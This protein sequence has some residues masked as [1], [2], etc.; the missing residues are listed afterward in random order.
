MPFSFFIALR[1]LQPKRT[2][3][4]IMTLLSV[5]GVCLGVTV[6]MVVIAVMAGFEKRI[7]DTVLGFEPHVTLETQFSGFLDEDGFPTGNGWEDLAERL[8]GLE[9]VTAVSPYV[10]TPAFLQIGGEPTSAAA[11]GFRAD[12][13]WRLEQLNK[14]NPKGTVDLSGDKIVIG[15]AIANNFGLSIGNK[16]TVVSPRSLRDLVKAAQ[17]SQEA[18]ERGDEEAARKAM[19]V[20]SDEAVLPLELEIGAIFSSLQYGEIIILPLHHAQHIAGL[21]ESVNGIGVVTENAYRAG[22]Y[23][24]GMIKVTPPEWRVTTW[25]ERHQQWFNAVAMERTMMYFVLF[26]ILFVAGFSIMVTM[27]TVTVQKRQDIGVIGALGGHVNQIAWIFLAQGMVVGVI[28]IMCGLGLGGLILHQRNTIREGI[29]KLTNFQIFDSG[30]YGLVEIPAR[31]LPKDLVIISVGAFVLC[32]LAALIPA[33][34]AA[35]VDPAKALRNL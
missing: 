28:G 13:T 5:I 21:E 23:V 35:R 7:K 6:L 11:I 15:S 26:I 4:S 8:E 12:D 34:F 32:T 14:L 25:M 29:Q 2:F 27:I 9:S 10:S 30:V 18:R 3:V 33:L 31:I 20:V 1:Y 24:E 22:E 16:I 19:E 17:K